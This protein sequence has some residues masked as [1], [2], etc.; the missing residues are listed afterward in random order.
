[1]KNITAL[2]V[3]FTLILLSCKDNATEKKADASMNS[4]SNKSEMQ[5]QEWEYLF[6]GENMDSWHAFNKDSI[7]S[8]WQI[9]G[10]ALVFT[11]A[12]NRSGTENLITNNS[13]TSFVLSL[14][15][16]IS[17][18]GNSGV[19]WAVQEQD[20]YSEPYLTGP[21]I[22]VL[23]NERH[24]DA[25]V[26]GKLHQAGALYDM[27]APSQ[28]VANPAGEWNT[29][30]IKIDYAANAGSVTLNGTQIVNFPVSFLKYYGTQI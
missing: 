17:E 25:K 6:D 30:E 14:D 20:Q 10:D 13:Y 15:W 8:Q 2:C 19:M 18:G 3:A 23:D 27:I 1:M 4:S 22:Q 12:E 5:D 9:E 29:C 28:N 7:S 11:P 24:P 21:E 26:N 16:K